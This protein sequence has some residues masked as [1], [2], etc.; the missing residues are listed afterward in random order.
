MPRG[1]P[2]SSTARPVQVELFPETMTTSQILEEI[3]ALRESLDLVS[4]RLIQLR[5][6]VEN[7]SANGAQLFEVRWLDAK[8]FHTGISLTLKL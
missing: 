3:N 7:V 1:V 5:D 4:T 6:R 8:T 2:N